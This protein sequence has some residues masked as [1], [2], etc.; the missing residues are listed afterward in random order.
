MFDAAHGDWFLFGYLLSNCR[1]AW[2]ATLARMSRRAQETVHINFLNGESREEILEGL[3]LPLAT[4]IYDLV[5][6]YVSHMRESGRDLDEFPLSSFF[7]CN[8][9]GETLFSM[10]EESLSVKKKKESGISKY[11]FLVACLTTKMEPPKKRGYK[12]QG[13]HDRWSHHSSHKIHRYLQ[14]RMYQVA[15]LMPLCV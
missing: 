2:V 6:P 4:D 7:F 5:K 11:F 14:K 12:T 9:E 3:G 15:K 8:E 10:V 13:A 1:N